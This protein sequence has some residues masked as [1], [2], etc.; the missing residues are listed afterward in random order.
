MY[1]R[2]TYTESELATK[3]DQYQ[4][5]AAI[6]RPDVA[7]D[8][9]HSFSF[10]VRDSMLNVGPTLDFH[11]VPVSSSASSDKTSDQQNM[12]AVCGHGKNGCLAVVH[13]GVRPDCVIEVPLDDCC[14]IWAV[15]HEHSEM[16]GSSD[17]PTRVAGFPTHSYLILSG[18]TSSRILATGEELEEVSDNVDVYVSGPTIT[19]GN[20][21]GNTHR[22][23]E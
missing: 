2:P 21:Q 18:S 15:Y 19:T 22:V 12:V 11:M 9:I 1:G 20:V 17:T 3:S 13:E 23:T 16:S 5:S 14:R 6:F 4:S 8:D 7:S 10:V